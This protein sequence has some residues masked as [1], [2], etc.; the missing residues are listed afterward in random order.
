M[1]DLKKQMNKLNNKDKLIDTENRLV[2]IRGKRSLK[3]DEMVEEG[4]LYCDG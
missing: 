2:V 3:V 4:Q 1:W